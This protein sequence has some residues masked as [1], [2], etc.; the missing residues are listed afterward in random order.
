MWTERKLL[1]CW[2][3]QDE[4]KKNLEWCHDRSW[5]LIKV[6]CCLGRSESRFNEDSQ[7]AFRLK[8][9][10]MCF[11]MSGHK[12]P[13]PIEKFRNAS[14]LA[15]IQYFDLWW[16]FLRKMCNNYQIVQWMS[17]WTSTSSSFLSQMVSFSTGWRSEMGAFRSCSELG[18]ENLFVVVRKCVLTFLR[19]ER[20][21]MLNL[22]FVAYGCKWVIVYVRLLMCSMNATRV[23]QNEL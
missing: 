6:L 14:S 23:P 12:V 22:E 5:T 16:L 15:I 11:F 13:T 20:A 4:I 10:L 17:N 21:V 18:R 7:A 19:V 2:F 8:S 1:S 3:L 9:C